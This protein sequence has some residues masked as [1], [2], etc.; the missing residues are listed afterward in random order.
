MNLSQVPATVKGSTRICSLVLHRFGS[1]VSWL[2]DADFSAA[3][4]RQF[5]QQSPALVL[6]FA[7]SYLVFVHFLEEYVYVVAHQEN[8]VMLAIGGGVHSKL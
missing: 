7:A 4:Q 2:V 3:G 6:Y 8:F 1:G 5:D